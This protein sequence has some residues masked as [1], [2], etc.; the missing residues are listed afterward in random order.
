MSERGSS[1]RRASF[2]DV[3]NG[4]F[5][6]DRL[7][8]IADN[9]RLPT[10]PIV[11]PGANTPK[12]IHPE[13]MPG[14]NAC[15][16]DGNWDA[17]VGSCAC[18]TGYY[19]PRCQFQRL[20]KHAHGRYVCPK[21]APAESKSFPMGNVRARQDGRG[22]IVKFHCVCTGAWVARRGV[23]FALNLNASARLVGRGLVAG[24]SLSRGYRNRRLCKR[25]RP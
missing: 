5:Q 25:S 21:R 4:R 12:P 20:N 13:V 6:N 2:G 18:K 1:P 11:L 9:F 7:Q 23:S 24:K 19:G 22:N 10:A 14:P 3:L 16:G 8:H 15:C 17:V